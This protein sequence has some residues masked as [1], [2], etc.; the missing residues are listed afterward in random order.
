DATSDDAFCYRLLDLVAGGSELKTQTGRLRGL[1]T[2]AFSSVRG[3]GDPGPV[4]RGSNEQSNT[5]L[6]F[7]DRLLLK[8][9][10]RIEPG[11][12]PDFEVGRFLTETTAF[13]RVP[14]T[15][16]AIEYRKS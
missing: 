16:G 14:K 13:P 9:F 15:A 2:S 12:N 4:R 1:P 7:G 3:E 11:V 8:L 5:T 10:R 6:F